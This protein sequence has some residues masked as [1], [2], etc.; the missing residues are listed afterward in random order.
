M[1]RL[2]IIMICLSFF[3]V[4]CGK[5][6]EENETG[7][8]NY[9]KNVDSLSNEVSYDI[10]NYHLYIKSSYQGMPYN[11][12]LFSYMINDDNGM[13]IVEYKEITNKEINKSEYLE[14]GDYLYKYNDDYLDIIYYIANEDY[15]LISIE[16]LNN[17]FNQE[18]ITYLFNQLNF[19]IT[20]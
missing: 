5:T 15:L 1:K 16:N 8:I 20:K 9:K 6:E 17:E 19:E 2:L 18:I 11:E 10:D 4:G 3:I 13:F 12:S 7:D 14:Y